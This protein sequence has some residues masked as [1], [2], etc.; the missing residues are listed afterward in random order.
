LKLIGCQCLQKLPQGIGKLVNLRHLEIGGTLSLCVLTKGIGRLDSLRTLNRFLVSG[1]DV[2]EACQIEDLKNLNL[3]R[4][5]LRI[6]GFVKLVDFMQAKNVQLKKKK[7]H[8]G[9]G[10]SVHWWACKETT[11]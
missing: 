6:E 3:L 5:K 7:M 1:G 4:R 8:V 9:L 11:R 2:S 10:T